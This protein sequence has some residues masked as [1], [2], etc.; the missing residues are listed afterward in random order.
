MRG[1]DRIIPL[2]RT[3]K[4]KWM[5]ELLRKSP[6][7][8]EDVITNLR[9]RILRNTYEVEAELV[10]EKIVQNALHVL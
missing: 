1:P 8:R 9:T 5:K 4:P 10:A 6:D 7:I 3:I 2:N